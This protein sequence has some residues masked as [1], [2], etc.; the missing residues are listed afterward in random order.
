MAGELSRR[1]RPA[2]DSLAET[3]A[4]LEAGID[5]S[6]ED[7][8]FISP[9]QLR[10]RIERIDALL[11]ELADNS[12]RFERL[13]HEPTF[14]LLGRPNAGKSTLLNALAGSER[15]V[16]SDIAGTTRDVLSAELRLRRGMVRMLDVAGLAEPADARVEQQMMEQAGRAAQAADFV[17]FVRD[18]TDARPHLPL[19]RAADLVVVTK[20]DRA[21]PVENGVSAVSGAGLDELRERLDRIAFGADS[22]TATLALNARHLQALADA[23]MALQSAQNA[24]DGGAEIAALELREALDALGR[25][26]GQVSPDELLGRIFAHF[27]IG[28]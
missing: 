28:K 24:I 10:Q 8:S 11:C 19:P 12:A 5:F 15:A 25:V 1:L 13:A 3:L 26:L 14:V 20:C 23:R 21:G 27:C 17:I 6:D 9:A 18:V 7:I 2:M 16:V 22:G 4:L